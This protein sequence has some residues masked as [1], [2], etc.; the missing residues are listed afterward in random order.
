MFFVN[1]IVCGW[2]SHIYPQAIPSVP[3]RTRLGWS[4]DFT[5]IL[6]SGQW[7]PKSLVRA[8]SELGLRVILSAGKITNC[9]INAAAINYIHAFCSY[10]LLM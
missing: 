2:L 9:F 7:R 3:L 1:K 4:C 10:N 8:G 5:P 6:D